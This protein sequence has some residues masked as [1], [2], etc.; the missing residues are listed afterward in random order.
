MIHLESPVNIEPARANKK[1]IPNMTKF[2][3]PLI[4]LYKTIPQSDAIALGPFVIFQ[5]KLNV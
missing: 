1:P 4:S 2:L 3:I 5:E